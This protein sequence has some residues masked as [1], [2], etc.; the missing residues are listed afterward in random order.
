[1]TRTDKN[2]RNV[3]TVSLMTGL[4]LLL[5]SAC[6]TL[7]PGQQRAADEKTCLGYGFKPQTDAMA[8][9]RGDLSAGCCQATLKSSKQ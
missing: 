2:F 4:A 7:T 6:T 8:I 9:T 5:L 1:M 3:K